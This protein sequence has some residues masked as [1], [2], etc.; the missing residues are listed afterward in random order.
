MTLASCSGSN[1]FLREQKCAFSF[2]DVA[3]LN[4]G[5]GFKRRN[6]GFGQTQFGSSGLTYG[7]ST[8]AVDR[9]QRKECRRVK[10]ETPGNAPWHL[11]NDTAGN[12]TVARQP[13]NAEMPPRMDLFHE[14]QGGNRQIN[15]LANV[16]VR[17]LFSCSTIS[18]WKRCQDGDPANMGSAASRIGDATIK[19]APVLRPSQWRVLRGTGNSK[20]A[21]IKK[22]S[23][24]DELPPWM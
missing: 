14:F 18:T 6:F 17:W 9:D 2:Y 21:M 5:D 23:R 11:L 4:H 3:P 10:P 15:P 22:K 7:Y 19:R 24:F 1:S 13:D 20:L 16:V 12:I 8:L